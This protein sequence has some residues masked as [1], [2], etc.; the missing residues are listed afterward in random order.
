LATLK[1]KSVPVIVAGFHFSTTKLL[2]LLLMRR[3]Y[4]A[5]QI[6]MPDGSV[7]MGSITKRLADFDRDLPE[8]GKLS[9]IPDFSLP[10]YRRIL[11]L[12]REGST[13]VWFADMFG[14]KERSE[15]RAATQE[16]CESASKV[17]N[18]GEIRT[19]LAQSKLEV[20]LC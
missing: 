13:L 4:N 3:G 6:W 17:F 11:K 15:G 1:S 9:I 20:S 5:T 10:S 8:Y 2:A 14:S 19:E 16:W 7:D 12:L 18:L